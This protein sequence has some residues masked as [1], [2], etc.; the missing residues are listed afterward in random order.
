VSG[1]GGASMVA[2]GFGRGNE[3]VRRGDD[4]V[5]ADRCGRCLG[6]SSTTGR[7]WCRRPLA[8]GARR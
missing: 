4:G 2:G 5:K 8:R 6:S 1:V 7:R 3:L